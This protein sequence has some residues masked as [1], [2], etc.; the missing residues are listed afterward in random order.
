[1]GAFSRQP[2]SETGTLPETGVCTE[3]SAARTL[4]PGLRLPGRAQHGGHLPPGHS[5]RPGCGVSEWGAGER[6]DTSSFTVLVP[7]E[8]QAPPA[9]L[10]SSVEG[11]DDSPWCGLSVAR[12]LWPSAAHRPPAAGSQ[13]RELAQT[14]PALQ[15]AGAGCAPGPCLTP[16]L[17]A[18][19]VGT[20]TL[21]PCGCPQIPVTG[22][23]ACPPSCWACGWLMAQP[24]PSRVTSPE[25]TGVPSPQDAH[26]A[27]PTP[28][29]LRGGQSQRRGTQGAHAQPLPR[30]GTS[31]RGPCLQ[32]LRTPWAERTGTSCISSQE[33][34]GS[35]GE[36][37]P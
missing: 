35:C 29:S 6:Q 17:A 1:M 23:C 13:R 25:L 33:G 21:S 19:Q 9:T 30:G 24:C 27:T 2:P 3:G 18:P 7:S 28:T 22:R 5:T 11:A 26:E 15:L 32:G 12:V 4:P 36:R 10:L 14:R 37:D 8:S 34:G 31:L 20:A 16:T